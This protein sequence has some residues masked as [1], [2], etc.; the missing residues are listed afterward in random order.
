V[1]E[2]RPQGEIDAA[3]KHVATRN[4]PLRI[5][6][7]FLFLVAATFVLALLFLGSCLLR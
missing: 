3:V 5:F 6:K 2:H 4:W 7:A 1:S